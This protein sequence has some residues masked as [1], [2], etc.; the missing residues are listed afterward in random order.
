M[1]CDDVPS[2][3]NLVDDSLVS[4][5]ATVG[6]RA[7]PFCSFHVARLP[8]YSLSHCNTFFKQVKDQQ[9]IGLHVVQPQSRL[10]IYRCELGCLGSACYWKHPWSSDVRHNEWQLRQ[11]TGRV[12]WEKLKGFKYLF[13]C[14]F[15]TVFAKKSRFG[16]LFRLQFG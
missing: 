12:H 1:L 11:E 2:A 7:G 16:K 10:C 6:E 4:V 5:L 13:T 8:L 9:N 14:L 15:E 3:Q